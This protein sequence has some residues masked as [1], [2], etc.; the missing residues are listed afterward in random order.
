MSKQ[1]LQLAA[2]RHSGV[3]F[4]ESLIAQESLQ[5]ALLERIGGIP[6]FQELTDLFYNRI[7]D[8][9]NKTQEDVS[10]V[11]I[12]SSSNKHEAKENLY[13]FLVQT[14]G[15]PPLYRETKGKFTRLAGRHANYNI[16]HASAN[17]WLFHM[18]HAAQQHS[19]LRNDPEA[20]DALIK[21]FTY[22]A[23]YIVVAKQYM[24]SDQLSGG[25]QIDAGRAW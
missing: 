13:R 7:F 15:G 24:R 6:G 16:T 2:H 21:Y 14:F 9:S 11:N 19:K 8:E 25:T 3:S 5:P 1:I 10:L 20:Q 12:F 22:T 18:V 17:R 4:S 23:H